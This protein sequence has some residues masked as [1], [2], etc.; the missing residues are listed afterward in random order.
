MHG[1]S[2]SNGSVIQEK[3]ESAFSKTGAT[4][5]IE[6]TEIIH[7]SDDYSS[8]KNSSAANTQNKIGNQE[9]DFKL[10]GMKIV[11]T[12]N[13]GCEEPYIKAKD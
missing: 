13:L 11:E 9:K 1:T 12:N 4:Q 6:R 5:P 8:L 10:N 2:P 3:T 7:G